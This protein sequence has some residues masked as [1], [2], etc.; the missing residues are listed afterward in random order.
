MS[1]PGENL[2]QS[3]SAKKCR[4]Q[5]RP[6]FLLSSSR[7]EPNQCDRSV[8]KRMFKESR[9]DAL[10]KAI[11]DW[12]LGRRHFCPWRLSISTGPDGSRSRR[13]VLIA[14]LSLASPV[15]VGG[16]VHDPWRRESA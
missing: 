15:F 8:F 7:T 1:K 3:S 6:A 4:T 16:F 5:M 2:N 9:C 11:A 14:E 12:L 10:A 13:N